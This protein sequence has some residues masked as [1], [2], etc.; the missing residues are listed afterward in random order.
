[1]DLETTV[2]KHSTTI[3]QNETDIKS[4]ADS[5]T[6]DTLNNTVENHTTK[7]SQNAEDISVKADSS[8]VNQLTGDVETNSA[9]IR[10]NA[11]EISQRLTSTEVDNLVEGK[12]YS[13]V[14]HM[15]NYVSNTAEGIY[16]SLSDVQAQIPTEIG[17]RNLLL[18]S[19][20]ERIYPIGLNHY[21]DYEL[22]VDADYVQG[23]EVTISFDAKTSNGSDVFQI[24]PRY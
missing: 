15:E 3:S 1:N 23:Q 20:E 22:S 13:T 17:G 19:K 14:S 18:N 6:V 16:G 24:C 8:T 2:S 5:S 11:D 4:K 12:G 10:I 21:E 7:I 9:D